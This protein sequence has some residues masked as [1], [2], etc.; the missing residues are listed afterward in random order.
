MNNPDFTFAPND[1]REPAEPPIADPVHEEVPPPPPPP[2]AR[3][4]TP[5]LT[6]LLFLV[7]A[8][9]L[10]VVWADPPQLA[11]YT[12]GGAVER[13]GAKVTALSAQD[14]QVASQSQALAQQVQA[15]SDRVDKL[16]KNA[17][18]AAAPQQSAPS[19]D[20]GDL[21]KQVADLSAK[22]D[23]LAARPAA[24]PQPGAP[25]PDNGATQQALAD[26]AQ[27]VDQA[28]AAQSAQLADLAAKQKSDA[29]A[30]R[31]RLDQLE[32][33]AG[34]VE[35]VATRANAMTR[36]QAAEVALLAGQKLGNI[37][38]APPALA[39]FA[40]KAPPTDAQLR[41]AFPEVADHA[42]GVSQPDLASKSLLERS[43]LR[44]QESVTVRQGDDV[45]V[46]DPAAGILADAQ[47]KVNSDDLQGAVAALQKLRGPAA[48]AVAPW[49]EQVNAVLAARAA[50]A[51]M[52]AHS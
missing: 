17:A 43:W 24:A 49:V 5:L 12:A 3:R 30:L 21:Q 50:L 45:L 35:G 19:P 41:E 25:A 11:K 29:D 51:S 23:A 6:L 46:G 13:L 34:Q 32:K 9:G 22:V 40:N 36:V 42:R 48:D 37:P 18:P 52:A 33:G 16:E 2:P 1:P 47:A 38:G 44:L 14:D 20:V 26:L 39:R 31:T 27:K 8:G 7:L 4:G 28:T 15:L 10:Y